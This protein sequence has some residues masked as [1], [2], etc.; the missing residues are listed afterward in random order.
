MIR[1]SNLKTT[2][3]Y[4]GDQTAIQVCGTAD[5]DS[6][7]C[8]NLNRTTDSMGKII[9]TVDAQGGL[10]QYWL[11]ATGNTLALK[12]AKG[13]ITSA[14]YN[15]IGQRSS[16][17]DPNQGTWS[18]AYNAL[19]EVLTQTDARGIVTSSSYDKLG[20]PLTRNATID[21]TGD[22]V[23]D[24]IND[25][26]SYDPLNAI[27]KPATSQRLINGA[28]ERRQTSSYDSL[29]R[30]IQTDTT[31]QIAAGTTKA[32][33]QTVAYDGNYDRPKSTGYPNGEAVATYYSKYG[34]P[35]RSFNPAT[36]AVYREIIAVDAARAQE[37]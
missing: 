31:Q 32:Y 18:F 4:S 25:S 27:G 14:K 33:T 8:L 17:T 19:G 9:E 30:P 21:T 5:A 10:T 15:P 13:S 36:G 26:W 24:A 37:G 1:R 23:A 6:S 28:I 20:R 22:N 34:I 11:D 12:D 7:R 35:I 3:S 2:Y 29:S 16:V